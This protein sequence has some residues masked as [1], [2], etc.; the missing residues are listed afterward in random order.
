MERALPG[1]RPR[2]DASAAARVKGWV[3]A[4]LPP[5]DTRTVLVTELVCGEPGCPPVETVIALFGD[6]ERRWRLHKPMAVVT[7]DDV[8]ATLGT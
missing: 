5:D 6:D 2:T 7:E 4:T 1:V 3:A 8:R